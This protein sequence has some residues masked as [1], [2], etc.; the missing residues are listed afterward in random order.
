MLYYVSRGAT[1]GARW[2]RDG[3]ATIP[4]SSR[5]GVTIGM[6]QERVVQSSW[7]RPQH[8]NRTVTGTTVRVDNGQHLVPLARDVMFVV[9]ELFKS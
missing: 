2:Y 5:S 6:T 3:M 8:I 1:R 7:G 9:E 4:T